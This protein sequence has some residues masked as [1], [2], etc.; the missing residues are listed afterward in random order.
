MN[1][2][3][4][5]PGPLAPAQRPRGRVEMRP[6]W[7]HLLFLHWAVEPDALRFL[8]PPGL[9]LDLFEDK[10]YVGLVPFAM[11][12]VRPRRA[13]HFGPLRRAFED[14]L[15]VN[16]RTYVHV[17]GRD[18]GVWFWS[19]D[20]ANLPAVCAARA[21]FKL[22]YFWARMSSQQRGA[23]ITY[24]SRRL[25]PGPKPASC[26]LS[27]TPCGEPTPAGQAR[28]ANISWSNATF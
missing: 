26:A 15:E 7:H 22:P 10:A 5:H 17:A 9:E 20:A 12:R 3:P 8:L 1:Q 16:V 13:P 18:P 6:G 24:A 19:L 25:W 2:S 28:F 21:W 23:T 14:F 11:T 27:Y 4:S